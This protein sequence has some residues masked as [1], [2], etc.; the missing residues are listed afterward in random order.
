MIYLQLCPDEARQA[1]CE[2]SNFGFIEQQV[3]TIDE[4]C[5][6]MN[7]IEQCIQNTTLVYPNPSEGIFTIIPNS[8][9]FDTGAELQIQVF[10]IAGKR[11]SHVKLAETLSDSYRV[12]LREVPDGIYLLLIAQRGHQEIVKIVKQ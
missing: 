12:N 9:T 1:K 2:S 3:F 5:A 10:D 4:I 6:K 11:I 8:E 7:F